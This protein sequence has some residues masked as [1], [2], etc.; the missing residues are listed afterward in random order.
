MVSEIWSVHWSIWISLASRSKGR[1]SVERNWIGDEITDDTG[2]TAVYEFRTALKRRP[3]DGFRARHYFFQVLRLLY[4]QLGC[5]IM[6]ESDVFIRL[7][8][9]ILAE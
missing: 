3:K 8:G 2:S 6:E 7:N 5:K 4:S 9:R 1:T